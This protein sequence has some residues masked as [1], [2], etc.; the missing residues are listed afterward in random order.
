MVPQTR[1][2]WY[3]IALHA[4]AFFFVIRGAMWF[5]EKAPEETNV[6]MAWLSLALGIGATIAACCFAADWSK[7][8]FTRRLGK[9]LI[10]QFIIWVCA[11]IVYPVLQGA[12]K[13]SEASTCIS[14]LR[15]LGT[16]MEIY[17]TDFDDR[18][19]PG[20]RWEDLL[21]KYLGANNESLN[22]PLA[23]TRYGYAMNRNMALMPADKIEDPESIIL[24]FEVESSIPNPCGASESEVFRHNET[25]NVFL[26]TGLAR[27]T[28]KAG[29]LKLKWK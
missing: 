12:R 4:V 2:K 19:P 21:S 24:L 29:M 17:M 7:N 23:Q 11:S 27:R 5:S 20:D 26:V 18:F 10:A 8:E 16:A 9:A 25:C 14:N 28:T 3:A 22:C 1:R 13:A 15:S 6:P